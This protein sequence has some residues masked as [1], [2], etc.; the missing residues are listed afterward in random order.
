MAGAMLLRQRDY[1]G[2]TSRDVAAGQ[3]PAAAREVY[4][5]MCV[6][7]GSAEYWVEDQHYK[8]KV[9]DILLVPVGVMVGATLKARGCPFTR[10]GVWMSRRYMTFMKLQDDE[11]D[12]GF[13]RAGAQGRYLLRLPEAQ[14][15][16]LAGA[17][18]TLAEECESDRMNSELST[19]AILSALLVQINRMAQ[20]QGDDVLLPG[21][22]NRL[23]P[24]LSYIHANCT[25]PLSVDGLAE[26]F[27]YSPSHLAHSFKKQM[28]TSLYH[29]VLLRRLQIGREAMLAGVPVKEA[30]QRCGF[31]DY[32]GFYR[33]F[34][35][36]F[37]LSP[38]QYKKR[39]Q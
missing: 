17:F 31:G 33:A 34:T 39:N 2:G 28:G 4:E 27:D 12:Y 18:E 30:Y 35:K 15:E 13:A 38:Q 1:E 20:A 21:D 7:E 36:E 9:G 37:G 22:D 16:A 10:H 29:Y 5:L 23:S 8:L 26:Q 19:K 3:I 25:E 6:T 24:V 32:A 14:A 11:A